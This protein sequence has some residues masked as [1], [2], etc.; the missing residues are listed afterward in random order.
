MKYIH[1]TTDGLQASVEGGELLELQHDV[2]VCGC[3]GCGLMETGKCWGCQKDY[4]NN[5][6]SELEIHSYPHMIPFEILDKIPDLSL[7]MNLLINSSSKNE[8]REMYEAQVAR[9]VTDG[10]V[11][12]LAGVF[13]NQEPFTD[14]LLAQ[15]EEDYGQDQIFFQKRQG[16]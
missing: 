10:L 4:C 15:L 14:D 13:E 6:S 12:D 8:F 7:D 16:G 1:V 11:N 2:Y 5:L 9:G 3:C